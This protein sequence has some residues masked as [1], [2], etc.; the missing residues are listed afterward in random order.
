MRYAIVYV[1]TASK[2]LEKKEIERILNSSKTWNNENDVTGL[3]LFSEGNFF[4]IIE[5]EKKKIS[6]LFEDIKK[7]KRHHDIIQIFGKDIHKE[8]YDGYASD[9]VL[10]S[11]DYDQ[12][13]FQHYLNQ[14][15]VLEKSAQIAVENI[16]KVF[17]P[18]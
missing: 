5:G 14:T 15:K 7:D 16:L 12:E 8:A 10:D 1:S 2:D 11:A 3:L 4:Q 9:F 6:E 13:K 18:I 17:L